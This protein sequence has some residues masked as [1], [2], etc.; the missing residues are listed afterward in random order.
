VVS[1]F[2]AFHQLAKA[3]NPDLVAA[4]TATP[5]VVRADPETCSVQFNPVGKTPDGRDAF[6]S[7]CDVAKSYLTNSGISYDNEVAP[8]G[9]VAQVKIG[10]VILDS[11]DISA[12]DAKAQKAAKDAFGAK[13]KTAL[14]AANY[15]DKAD[16]AKIDHLTVLAYLMVFVVAATAL[17][18]PHPLYGFVGTLSYW[19]RFLWGLYAGN[20]CRHR[21]DDREYVFGALVSGDYHG[22]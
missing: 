6:S 19:H 9:A 20:S 21:R 18:G 10:T 8:A 14:K 7:S 12:L 11:V 16:P 4:Q 17:Y 3:A 5:I 2:P 1:F 22:H 13:L 15:P